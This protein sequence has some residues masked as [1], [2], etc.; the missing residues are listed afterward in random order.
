MTTG[1]LGFGDHPAYSGN[2]DP[3]FKSKGRNSIKEM[4]TP[5]DLQERLTMLRSTSDLVLAQVENNIKAVLLSKN[6]S[7]EAA[8]AYSACSPY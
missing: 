3:Y 4:K 8:G 7:Y 6:F 2:R 5:E 1:H